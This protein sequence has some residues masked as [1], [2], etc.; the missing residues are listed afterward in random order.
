MSRLPVTLVMLVKLVVEAPKSKDP[1]SFDLTLKL[2]LLAGN[3]VLLKSCVPVMVILTWILPVFSSR[4]GRGFSSVLSL[5]SPGKRCTNSTVLLLRLMEISEIKVKLPIDET[6][7][8]LIESL[9][10]TVQK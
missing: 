1:L 3:G 6:L 7:L 5:I 4:K 9:A 2:K 8:K 10:L